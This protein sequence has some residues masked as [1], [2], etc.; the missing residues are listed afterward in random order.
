MKQVTIIIP[1][2]NE[3]PTLAQIIAAVE[4]APVSGLKK[5]IIIIDDASTDGSRELLK[6]YAKKHQ[7]IYHAANRG[8]GA[9]VRDGLANAKGDVIIIQDAD[10]EYDPADYEML[11][12]PI[13]EGKA[14]VVYGSR[15]KGVGP[16][17]VNYYWH[18][19][20][21]KLLTMLTNMVSNLNLTDVETCYKVFRTD[22]L[23]G[24]TLT[25]DRFGLDTEI[26]IK[27]AKA[28]RVFYEVGISYYGRSYAEGKKITWRDGF[29]HLWFILKF[30]VFKT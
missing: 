16:H 2:Y 11:L 24:I 19:V 14:E 4:A 6:T 21:N 20:G 8:K 12:G 7:V 25:T 26:T 15:F 30:G 23:K 13:V 3:A 17:R 27:L 9:S 5:D 1:V 22:A 28:R 18:Y 29:S 10:L